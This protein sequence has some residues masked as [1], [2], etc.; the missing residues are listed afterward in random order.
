[1]AVNVITRAI[2]REPIALRKAFLANPSMND[3]AE[4][5]ALPSERTSYARP[6]KL[7]S[8]ITPTDNR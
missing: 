8:A 4:L 1:M 3:F 2:D 5:S 6:R 7:A